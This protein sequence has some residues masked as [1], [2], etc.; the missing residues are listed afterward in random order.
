MRRAEAAR[1][2]ELALVQVERVDLGGTRDSCALNHREPDR[3]AADHAHAGALPHG[4][5]VQHGA[6]AG[7]DR[8]PDQAGLLR[9]Q[10]RRQ[11][12]EG[13]TVHDRAGAERPG[14]E[15]AGHLSAVGEPHPR[16]GA[17]RSP[18]EMTRPAGAPGALAARRAPADDDVIARPDPF[19]ALAD[20]LDHPRA[21][22]ADQN[23][24]LMSPAAGLDDVQVRVADAAR[25]DLDERLARPG[26]VELELGDLEAALR[27][28]D[29]AAIH[30]SSRPAAL[31]APSSARVRS[32]SAMRCRIT[33]STPSCPPTASP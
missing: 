25:L 8:A 29:S 24:Q 20:G 10:L 30:D 7:C 19:D 12:H 1:S 4:G 32:V 33:A 23:G 3:A 31:S 14:W 15:S 27:G 17:R 28:Q 21:L 9:G 16:T 18:A 2:L 11:R 6:D 5:G 26:L 22:V 13:R